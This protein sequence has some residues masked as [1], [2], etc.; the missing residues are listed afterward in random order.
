MTHA[1]LPQRY[2]D[3]LAN[4]YPGL[5]SLSFRLGRLLWAD[6]PIEPTEAQLQAYGQLM[7]RGDR[8]ADGWALEENRANSRE[9]FKVFGQAIEGGLKAVRDP[10]DNLRTLLEQTETEPMWLDRRLLKVGAHTSQRLG[11]AWGR[12]LGDLA[13]LGGYYS[14]AI[15]K[16]L[17]FTGSLESR[18]DRR[19]QETAQ[20]TL[21]ATRD[22]G[23]ERGK[24]GYRAALR[25]RMMHGLIRK[26]ITQNPEWRSDL[27]GIPI[28]QA[29]MIATNMAFSFVTIVAGRALGYLF[30]EEEVEG[31]LHLWRYIGYLM[32]ID[33]SQLPV[34]EH[35]AWRIFHVTLKL[36]PPPD[37]DSRALAK[38]YR[39]EAGKRFGEGPWA[40]FQ[41]RLEGNLRDGFA[42]YILSTEQ[43]KA[44]GI[45]LTPWALWPLPV[46]ARNLGLELLRRRVP[47]GTYVMAKIGDYQQRKAVRDW[48]AGHKASFVPVDEVKRGAAR[49]AA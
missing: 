34:T 23:L 7:M 47:G 22:G 24:E 41:E 11:N 44:L 16:P 10:S 27:W 31:H 15:T 40:R 33:A 21:A 9:W 30:S 20:F 28:N 46:A 45:P 18:T 37:E 12:I 2:Y 19:L 4:P 3:A 13:L 17:I 8:E 35:E 36:I 32:G 42:R 26:R 29:D 14:G 5:N 49:A 1:Q 48:S 25:V 43:A 39:E 6:G 38:A